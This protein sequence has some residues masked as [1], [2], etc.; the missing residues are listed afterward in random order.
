MEDLDR[1]YPDVYQAYF[2]V[3]RRAGIQAISVQSDVGMMGG[4]MAHEFI[5]VSDIGEDQ[6]ALCDACGYAANRQIAAFRKESPVEEAALPVQ[7]VATP[8]TQTIAA[9]AELLGIPDSR[10]AKAAF[11]MAGDKFIFA[12]VRGDMEVNETKLVN[13][14]GATELR[15]ARA[16]ELAAAGIVAGYAS[17]IGF[18]GVTVVVDDQVAHSPNLV[19]G[20]NRPGFHLRN[21]NFGR[22][23]QADVVTDIADAFEGAPCLQCGAPLRIVRGVEVGNL[24]KLGTKYSNALGATYLDEQGESHDIVMGSY[25]IGVGR[26]IAC[27]A[28]EFYDDK[29]LCWPISV[30]PYQ[31][32]LV[33]LD[34]DDETIA[35]ATE[36]AYQDLQH[37]GSEVL[38]DDRK[39]RAGVKFND[40]DLIGIPLRITI[41]RRTIAVGEAEFKLRSGENA[42]HVPLSDL[43]ATAKQEI[44]RLEQ[45]IT[46]T[47]RHEPFEAPPGP[48]V[49]ADL[50]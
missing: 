41:S 16:D 14:V 36:Q 45:A 40:A 32:Y 42:W 9:L 46:A 10:T 50:R 35:R 24:F 33:G 37:A 3:F 19:A 17:P 7:E 30:A 5:Y 2:N 15:P 11:F 38:Y 34:A 44:R 23:Y 39:V 31:I 43:V 28:Q 29:G 13:A 6:I 20:A 4:T 26:L 49:Q 48:Q 18:P 27:I 25:G 8:D 21:T 1:Y 12:V 22:D 47:L